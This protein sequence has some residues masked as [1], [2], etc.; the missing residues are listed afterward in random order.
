[1]PHNLDY[2]TSLNNL[3]FLYYSIGK[4]DEAEPLFLQA[5][6]LRKRILGENHS[7][8]IVVKQNLAICWVKGLEKGYF[9]I[10]VLRENPLFIQ[11]ITELYQQ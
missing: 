8:T 9:S 10:E 5:L 2:A 3:A 4:Y 1:M 6:E 7:N 11:I